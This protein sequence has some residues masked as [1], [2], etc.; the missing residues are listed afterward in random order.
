MRMCFVVQKSSFPAYCNL[1][2]YTQYHFI[3]PPITLEIVKLTG[4]NKQKEPDHYTNLFKT[5]NFHL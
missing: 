2:L 4:P 3:T 1:E 5:L